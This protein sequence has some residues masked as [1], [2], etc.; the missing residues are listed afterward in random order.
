[1]ILLDLRCPKCNAPVY[2]REEVRIVK[3]VAKPEATCQKC[4]ARVKATEP[5]ET[6]LGTEVSYILA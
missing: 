6:D 2:G 1:M 4:K 5:K 3:K